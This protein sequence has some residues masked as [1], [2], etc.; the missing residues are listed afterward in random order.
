MKTCLAPSLRWRPVSSVSDGGSM[1]FSK[2]MSLFF[3]AGRPSC[4]SIRNQTSWIMYA[5]FS[6]K[7]K[8]VQRNQYATRSPRRGSLLSYESPLSRADRMERSRTS[9]GIN[10]AVT[11]LL[12]QNKTHTSANVYF[13]M[14]KRICLLQYTYV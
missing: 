9:L 12:L 3:S 7:M 4:S 6:Q 10:N 2:E 8:R 14:E 11:R 1:H 5:V 13:I